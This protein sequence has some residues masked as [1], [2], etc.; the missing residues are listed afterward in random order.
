MSTPIPLATTVESTVGSGSWDG[1]TYTIGAAGLYSVGWGLIWINNPTGARNGHLWDGE[2]TLG[3]QEFPVSSGSS[4][5]I[6]SGQVVRRFASG[7]LLSVRGLQSSGGA[8]EVAGTSFGRN[9]LTITP[10]F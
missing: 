5:T 10:L 7:T 4:V 6:L 3:A 9:Y 8:L 2:N 1:T